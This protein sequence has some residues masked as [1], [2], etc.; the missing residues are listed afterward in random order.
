MRFRAVARRMQLN[1]LVITASQQLWLY[2]VAAERGEG[3]KGTQILIA[4]I[5]TYPED[6]WNRPVATEARTQDL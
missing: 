3:Y 1:G 2:W 4:M 6:K 5:H